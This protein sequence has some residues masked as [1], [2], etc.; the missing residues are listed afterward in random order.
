MDEVKSENCSK[1]HKLSPGE[2]DLVALGN[3]HVSQGI[4]VLKFFQGTTM[5]LGKDGA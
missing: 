1:G 3:N 2:E 4:N 5:F